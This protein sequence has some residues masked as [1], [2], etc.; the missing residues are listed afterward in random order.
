M[1]INSR[2]LLAQGVIIEKATEVKKLLALIQKLWPVKTSFQL[3]RYGSFHDGGYLIPDD[4]A[5]IAAC[6]SP[7]VDVNSSFER[8]LFV[9]NGIGSHL[10]DYSVDAPPP[11]I[12]AKSFIKKFL[13]PYDDDINISMDHWI[14][15]TP[16]YHLSQ[17]L[18]LQMDIEGA[19]Y[20]CML[21]ISD[22]L[23]Y[24]FRIIVIEIHRVECWA[25][26]FLFS[27]VELF[28]AKLLRYFYV[29]HNHPNNCCGQCNVGGVIMPRVFELTLIRKDRCIAQGF[30][31]KFPHFLDSPNI[32]NRVDLILPKHWYAS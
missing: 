15:D 2:E 18:L 30:C 11:G 4:L 16:D 29:I 20:A 14:K 1:Q 9:K 3:L 21:A 10:L 28:F 8:D 7:G 17:D 19:E 23:L 25:N 27:L 26:P 22:E 32:K 6:F 24:R 13:G 12:T 31:D 5:H